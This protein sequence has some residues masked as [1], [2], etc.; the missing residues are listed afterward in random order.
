[1][2]QAPCS[3]LTALADPRSRSLVPTKLLH[4]AS[5]SPV[6]ASQFSSLF[7]VV[8]LSL[9]C[10]SSLFILPSLPYVSITQ[11]VLTIHPLSPAF[12]ISKAWRKRAMLC[13]NYGFVVFLACGLTVSNLRRNQG[14]VGPI[15]PS[16]CSKNLKDL[17]L[18]FS[19]DVET[20]DD[21]ASAF[22][23]SPFFYNS[24]NLCSSHTHQLWVLALGPAPC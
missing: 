5:R 1:M 7:W 4:G 24:R 16:S 11:H 20:T 13:L 8:F 18:S 9:V 17:K 2:K 15:T 14:A 10:S 23:F 19:R 12:T 3:G 6:L 21:M 22:L